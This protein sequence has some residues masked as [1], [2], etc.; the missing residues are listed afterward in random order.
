MQTLH[1]MNLIWLD[2]AKLPNTVLFQIVQPQVLAPPT[3]FKKLIKPLPDLLKNISIPFPRGFIY[4]PI[5][6]ADR[7]CCNQKGKVLKLVRSISLLRIQSVLIFV[8]HF[9]DE[10][11]T[12]RCIVWIPKW[13]GPPPVQTFSVQ[14]EGG[15][16]KLP[17]AWPTPSTLQYNKY[18]KSHPQTGLLSMDSKAKITS[19]TSLYMKGKNKC[20]GFRKD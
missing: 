10:S 3:L 4:S 6:D 19:L 15:G 14:R 7:L 9:N 18:K 12:E 16:R 13:K 2:R 5:A 20:A 17:I 11:Y 8:Q 1:M